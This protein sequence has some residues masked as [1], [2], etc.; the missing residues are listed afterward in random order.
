MFA[1]C[2]ESQKKKYQWNSLRQRKEKRF[3]KKAERAEGIIEIQFNKYLLSTKMCQVLTRQHP[4]AGREDKFKNSKVDENKIFEGG[5]FLFYYLLV[6][7]FIF[8]SSNQHCTSHREVG[9][10]ERMGEQII[11]YITLEKRL[12]LSSYLLIC[13]PFCIFP[14]L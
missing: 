11:G 5:V 1:K 12:F 4:G 10:A 14:S 9:N 8:I 2:F 6:C 7:L 3:F 13:F